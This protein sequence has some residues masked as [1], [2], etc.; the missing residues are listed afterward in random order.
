MGG[1]TMP[2][3]DISNN[4]GVNAGFVAVIRPLIEDPA[5]AEG[6]PE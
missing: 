1:D 6:R 3:M 2:M 4:I 5:I